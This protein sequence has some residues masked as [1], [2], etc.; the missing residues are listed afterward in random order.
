MREMDRENQSDGTE[1]QQA[2]IEEPGSAEAIPQA[3]M[4]PD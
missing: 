4:I 1:D 2:K 3:G